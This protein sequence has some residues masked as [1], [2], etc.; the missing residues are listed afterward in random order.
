MRL[1]SIPG[2]LSILILMVA[3]SFSCKE[4]NGTSAKVEP[5]LP[6][7]P[8]EELKYLLINGEATDFIFH[9]LP[10]SVSQSDRESVRNTISG[11]GMDPVFENPC[12]SIGRVFIQ[13][14]GEI[15]LEAE[16]HFNGNEC[17]NYIFYKNGKATYAGN[18]RN[19]SIEFYK[20]LMKSAE[21]RGK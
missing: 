6:P 7:L 19:N 13:V 9:N 4:K 14:K 20:E 12:P 8:A 2:K 3:F 11:F 17:N 16:I 1:I 21:S 5:I 10:F 18:I 15:V